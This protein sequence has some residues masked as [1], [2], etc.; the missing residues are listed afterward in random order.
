MT[1]SKLVI[2]PKNL[3]DRSGRLTSFT[4]ASWGDASHGYVILAKTKLKTKSVDKIVRKVKATSKSAYHGNSKS[5]ASKTYVVAKDVCANL[6]DVSDSE[7][8]N[9]DNCKSDQF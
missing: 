7:G 2:L 4:D 8:S 3:D 5:Y 6:V 9:D 1:K